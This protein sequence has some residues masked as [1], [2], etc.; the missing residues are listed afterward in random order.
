M[1]RVSRHASERM[2]ERCGL[3]KSAI[4][5]TAR[6]AFEKGHKREDFS[7]SFRRYL[8][9][10]FHKAEG[11]LRIH[12]NHIWVFM[13]GTLVTVWGIPSPYR[14]HKPRKEPSNETVEL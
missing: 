14:K 2:R 10:E 7:G 6:R 8:D 3:P 12:G 5:K 1:K 13:H 11:D 4:E 9:K